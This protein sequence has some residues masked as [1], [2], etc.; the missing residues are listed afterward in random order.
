M[1]IKDLLTAAPAVSEL[2]VFLKPIQPTMTDPKVSREEK[3]TTLNIMVETLSDK[4]FKN[5]V[6]AT[7]IMQ[8]INM[9]EDVSKEYPDT[10]SQVKGILSWLPRMEY[11]KDKLTKEVARHRKLYGLKV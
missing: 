8:I 2:G 10:E 9:K 4:T 1:G 3:R 6:V 11:H 7:Q 5:G